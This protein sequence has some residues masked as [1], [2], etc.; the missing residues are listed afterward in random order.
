MAVNKDLTVEEKLQALFS[1]QKMDS[2]VDEIRRLRGELP[3][4]VSDLE[5]EMEGLR[6]RIE[7]LEKNV[8]ELNKRIA[9]NQLR[10]K[11]SDELI[12][13][14]QK[15]QMN[16]KNNREYDAL[17]KEIEMQSLERDLAKKK[18]RDAE[19][20]IKSFNE[21]LAESQDKMKA[22][23]KELELKRRELEKITAETEK[24]ETSLLKKREKAGKDIEKRL[25]DA[26]ERIRRTYR[27]GLGVVYFERDSCG[28]CYG[29][30]PPQ[31]QLEIKQRKKIIVCEHCGRVLVDPDIETK[32]VDID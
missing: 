18:T 11:E 21:Y 17:T 9:D 10:G 29:K 15:Q 31:R 24:Q 4:E 19:K 22:K 14:Y 25:I 13:K 8:A 26:Y 20:E 2:E 27:N 3:I 23:E 16:V 1:L 32:R 12:E 28:G 30:I 7:N 6:M 5:D